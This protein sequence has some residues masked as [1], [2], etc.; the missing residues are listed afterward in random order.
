MIWGLEMSK[1]QFIDLIDSIDMGKTLDNIQDYYDSAVLIAII[2]CLQTHFHD[3]Q[4]LI[5]EFFL[6]TSNTHIRQGADL[7][8]AMI[9]EYGENIFNG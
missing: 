1:E 5:S 7:A 4:N 3:S 9:T 2:R 6:K 8:E